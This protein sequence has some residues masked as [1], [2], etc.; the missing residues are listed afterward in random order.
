MRKILIFK[1][2]VQKKAPIY[3]PEEIKL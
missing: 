1:L 3:Q 2:A